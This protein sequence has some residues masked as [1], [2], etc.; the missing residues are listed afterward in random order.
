[1][2]IILLKDVPKVG[3]RYD[4]K[5]V[6]SG[7]ALNML[8]PKGSAEPATPEAQKRAEIER[9]KSEGE[10]RLHE[11]LLV[12]NLKDLDGKTLTVSGK[13]NDRGHLFAGLHREEIAA[14]LRKQTELQIDPSYIELAHPLKEIGEHTV[15]VKG[16]GKSVT[17]K[18]VI[19]AAQA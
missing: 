16:G 10:R 14:E 17:F 1:M 8:I 18:L 9:K 11:E 7:Y 5:D 19:E 12:K 2:K 15:E 3:R 4:I 6:S 13:A